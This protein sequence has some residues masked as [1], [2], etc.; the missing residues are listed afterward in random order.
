MMIAFS[1]R[2]TTG[3]AITWTLY[4]LLRHPSYLHAIYAEIDALPPKTPHTELASF[5]PF[6]EGAISESLRL[7][8]P[9]PLEILENVSSRPI[10]LPQGEIVRPGEQVVWSAWVMARLPTF[11]GDDAETFRPERWIDMERRPTAFEWPVFHAGPRSCLGRPLARLEL[12]FACVELL[13]RYEFEMAWQGERAVGSTL[14]ASIEGGLPVR[15]KRRSE[16]DR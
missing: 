1:G 7:Y 15:V 11:W 6:L 3:Q 4:L 12:T 16:V 9:V 13:R 5:L 10:A 8:P 2:D 14:T